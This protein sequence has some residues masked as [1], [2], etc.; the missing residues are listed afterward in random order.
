MARDMTTIAQAP[1]EICDD[2]P[3]VTV[4]SAQNAGRTGS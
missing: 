1:S 3:A 2:E 4:P